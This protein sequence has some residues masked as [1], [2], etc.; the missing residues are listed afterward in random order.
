[1]SYDPQ[2]RRMGPPEPPPGAPVVDDAAWRQIVMDRLDTLR[3]SLIILAIVV[4]AALG[5][6]LYA[7]FREDDTANDSSPQGASSS[8]VSRLEDR[9][10]ELE[11]KVDDKASKSS[12]SNLS[13]QQ[14]QLSE[15]VAKL[16]SAGGD[17]ETAQ[18]VGDLQDD[19]KQLQQQVDDLEQQ[20]QEQQQ[21]PPTETTTT[22]P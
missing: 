13:D 22:T 12:V 5:L 6:A 17:D 21:Q 11:T 9:V 4:A 8:R 20:Q 10:D 14:K 7:A 2:G 19:V 1:M 15:D 18:A 3:T 16:K